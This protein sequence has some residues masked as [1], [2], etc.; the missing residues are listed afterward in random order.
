MKA[1]EYLAE[2]DKVSEKL[3]D[4]TATVGLMNSFLKEI[5]TL[6]ETR[7]AQSNPA[8]LSIIRE[9]NQKWDTLCKLDSHKRFK[10]GGFIKVIRH[11]V[12]IDHPIMARRILPLLDKI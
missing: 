1:K 7:K 11:R 10:K 3:G 8:M 12:T 4:R 9:L 2:F 6:T 5:A